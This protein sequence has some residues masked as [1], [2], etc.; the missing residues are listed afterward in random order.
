MPA[1]VPQKLRYPW[2]M[3][4]AAVL[5]GL[6]PILALE[7]LLRL[8]GLPINPPPL[9]PFV[10]LHNPQP[11][12]R[13]NSQTG[14]CEIAA[15][16]M[17][18]FRPASFDPAKPVNNFRIFALGGSTTQGEP[19]STETAFPEW[20]GLN[21]QASLP[22]SAEGESSNQIQYEVINCGG[23]SYASYRVLAILREVLNYSPD[24]IVIYTGHNEYLERRTYAG[25][26]EHSLTHRG[27]GWLSGSHIVQM[28]RSLA[29]QTSDRDSNEVQ[30]T[31]LPS[32]V[33]A[34][35]DY[36]GGLADY[37]RDD[38]WYQPVPAHFR[39]N[40]EQ[41]VDAC[42][43]AHIPLL[44][45]RPVSNLLDC[46]PIK[47][48]PAPQF[49][50]QQLQDFEQTWQ[51]AL[52]AGPNDEAALRR[53]L[54]LDPRHAGANYVLGQKQY[55]AGDFQ[56]A[57]AR[58]TLAKDLDVCPLRATTAIADAVS[59]V[60]R[61]RQVPLVDA[62]EMFSQRSPHG[63]VG[64]NW[65]V[66]HIHPSL[67]GHQLLGESLAKLCV[68]QG[69]VPAPQADWEQQRMEFYRAHLSQLNE[70][71][72]QRGKQRLAGLLLWTQGRAK[73]VRSIPT[74]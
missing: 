30:P 64:A 69:L 23:L 31:Q 61:S 2:R 14:R 55:A 41:M 52:S 67:E 17:N 25:Y 24:L 62:E 40:L 45:V 10:E 29:G 39:W 36:Q 22:N 21:L 66:D 20:L 60:A 33:E 59:E 53:A 50:Q 3:R 46:P 1:V 13:L 34:L 11:L 49:S 54:E 28:A 32:E 68:E 37:H 71:Y 35:L 27:L 72:F 5:L 7:V 38:P 47:F 26:H 6:L 58:L 4:L 15:E 16:R 74:P 63:I 51:A 9:D 42:Q 18:L 44:L 56:S 73:K 12:F 57:R 70:A 65:L 43:S 48:E 8:L 19:Y